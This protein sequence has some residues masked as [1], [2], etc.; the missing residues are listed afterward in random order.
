VDDDALVDD[1]A[2]VDDEDD[3]LTLV[4]FVGFLGRFGAAP[5]FSLAS[6]SSAR[7]TTSRARLQS[8]AVV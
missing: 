8:A 5:N 7:L 2:P 4:V 3:A 1:D 6:R